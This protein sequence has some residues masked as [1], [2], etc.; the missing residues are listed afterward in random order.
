MAR[1]L[2]PGVPVLLG[3]TDRMSARVIPHARGYTTLG[4][5]FWLLCGLGLALELVGAVVVLVRQDA[6]PCCSPSWR[7]ARPRS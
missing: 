1:M 4:I 7:S 3:F 6:A 5:T 2:E